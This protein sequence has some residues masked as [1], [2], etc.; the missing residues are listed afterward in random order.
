MKKYSWVI[1]LLVFILA[2]GLRAD[3]TAIYGT[4]SVSVTPNVLIIFDTSGSMSTADIP[5]A[6]Y[7]PAT[8]YTGTYTTN[9]V[10]RKDSSWG[11]WYYTQ[12]LSDYHNLNC[13][14]TTTDLESQGYSDHG[15]YRSYYSGTYECSS[16]STSR[17][18]LGNWI[19]YDRSTGGTMRTRIDVAKEVITQLITETTGVNFGLMRF[20]NDQG[21]RVLVTASDTTDKTYLIN[22]VNNL[23][24]SGWTPLAET[25]A[26]AG[27][28]FAGKKSWFNGSDGTYSSNCD[29]Y[30]NGCYQYQSPITKRC[31]KNYI[32]LMTDGEPTYDSDPKLSTGTYIN[33]DHIGDYDNDGN[34]PGT[35]ADHGSDYLDDVAKYLYE[36]D[37][38][39]DLGTSGEAFEKQN[40]VVYTIG[41]T[42]EQQLL[43]ETAQ[44]GGGKYYT[45][46]SISGLSEAFHEILAEIADVSGIYVS[47][48]VPVSRLNGTYAGNSLYV[49]FFKPK[50]DGRWDG[51]IKKYGIDS[52][53]RIID[54][55]GVLA[56]LDN[57][58]IKD[59]ARSF[60]STS[61]DGSDVV[62]GGI[63]Q[64]LSN[65]AVRHLYTHIGSPPSADLT[66]SSNAFSTANT[67]I[68]KD[69]LGVNDDTKKDSVIN[70][71]YGANREWKLG[72]ILHSRPSVVHYTSGSIIFAGGN[73]G[74]MHSFKDSD[75][76]ELWGFI[77]PDLLAGLKNLSDTSTTTHEYF[78]DGVTKVYDG[79]NQKILFFGER[80]GGN[81]Y[82]ALDV[83]DYNTPTYLYEIGSTF[84]HTT[85]GNHNGIIDGEEIGGGTDD[86]TILGQ[87]WSDPTVHQIKTSS[88]TSETVF[89]LSGGYDTNQDQATPNP[90]DT[91]GRAVFTINVSTGAISKFNVN[92]GYYSDMKNCIVDAS[93]FDTNGN[94][95]TNR[96]YA[97]D[98]GGNMFAFEDDDGDGT[99]SQSWL[100]SASAVD[101]VQRK[102]FFGPDAV[103]ETYGEMIYFG[104]GDRA[105]PEG[106]SVV[107]RVYAVKNRWQGSGTT[108]NESN[109]YDATEDLI[110]LGTDG[111]NGTKA[112]AR[113]ALTNMDGWFIKLDQHAGEKVTSPTTVYN[114]VV[115][116]TTYT[117]ESGSVSTG[118]VCE[119]ASGVGQARLY[120]LNYKTGEAAFEWSDVEETDGEGNTVSQGRSDR[121]IIIGTSIASAPVIAVLEG[122]PQIYVGVQGGVQKLD[123]GVTK[124]METFFWR[125]LNN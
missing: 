16:Y 52:V 70:D 33:G 124:N 81:H 113:D 11:H 24:A 56:T 100:F 107:D 88:S 85:D 63:G 116:F 51:N 114:G 40:V 66:A 109:L 117:P 95:L 79:T 49:G 37:L 6:Y 35:Y 112:A 26:E 87:S 62:S 120:A 23:T 12:I 48:V 55:D 47:P 73:D 44:N 78:V 46:N 65:Q 97:G 61:P 67:N 59:N 15:V 22:T 64:I 98:L 111:T 5:N 7:D 74:M 72:D 89:L 17:L 25:L 21:G 13:S 93:G 4:T 58:A 92:A 10:Y 103:E 3:D 108:L 45:A 54:A 57:G 2:P 41:F 104:T 90:E 96:I 82:Y 102:I 53:G 50:A 60:W 43:Q 71:I 115:Y 29:N 94:K 38:R 28:Y 121:S 75:G 76:S 39:S 77:P 42:S 19:N 27:L 86:H 36:N 1:I 14:D 69:T 106:T 68:T 91:K 99:W 125:Q 119:Q 30:G 20:N 110:V 31:Q 83:T 34:D 118:D 84:L 105:N 101:G 18:Y 9:A 32:I 8:T 123:P 122:G 80:R